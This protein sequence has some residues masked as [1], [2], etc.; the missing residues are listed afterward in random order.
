MYLPPIGA[1]DRERNGT[2]DDEDD[3]HNSIFELSDFGEEDFAIRGF[4][5][6]KDS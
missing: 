4:R 6:P 2:G 5:E 3:Q 1:P